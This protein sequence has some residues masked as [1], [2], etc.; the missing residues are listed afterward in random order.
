MIV[1]LPGLFSYLVLAHLRYSSDF[2][3]LHI[4]NHTFYRKDCDSSNRRGDGVGLFNTF[5]A[6]IYSDFSVNYNQ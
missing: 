5:S 3:A 4:K 6:V 2:A 1:A